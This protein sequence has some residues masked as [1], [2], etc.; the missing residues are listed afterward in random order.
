MI[1]FIQSNHNNIGLS[2][3]IIEKSFWEDFIKYF[4]IKK[5]DILK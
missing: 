1:N 4:K 2:I 5:N 3:K